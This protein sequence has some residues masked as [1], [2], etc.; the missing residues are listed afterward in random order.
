M[1]TDK[2]ACIGWEMSETEAVSLKLELEKALKQKAA[3]EERLV[4]VDA[5]LKECMQQLR[6]VR[7]EQEKRIHD[8]VM[9]ASND[10][11]RT[12]M[13]L[14]SK[15]DE[16]SKRLAKVDSEN[17]QLRKALLM[18]EKVIEELNKHRAKAEIDSNALMTRLESTEKEN[19]SLKYELRVLE[20]ELEIR[21]EEREFN[22]RTAD[23][24]NKQ[25]LENVKKIAKLESECQR[26][27]LLVRKRLP[28]PATLAKMKNEVDMLS[29]DQ[30]ET[31]RRKSNP[32]MV[33]SMDFS[34]DMASETPRKSKNY[35]N[36]QLYVMEEENRT[37][38]EAITK[39]TNELHFSRNMFA[40]EEPGRT[41]DSMH[42]LSR[43]SIS[44][45][46][47]D[48]KVS[49]AESWASALISE[50][51]QF[52]IGKQEGVPS[53]TVGASDMSLM[54]DFV[55]M[56]KLAVLAV[57]SPI[58][59]SNHGVE[60]SV[61]HSPLTVQ[62]SEN[63]HEATA[64]ASIPDDPSDKSVSN[65]QYQPKD[66]ARKLAPS[67]LDEILAIILE[68]SQ[69]LQRKPNDVLEEIK[70]AL[71]LSEKSS[72]H[73]DICSS[74]NSMAQR[75]PDESLNVEL[76]D[77]G[78][79]N[80]VLT[81]KKSN[82]K[83]QSNLSTSICKIVKL[84]E[85]I[86]IQSLHDGKSE[87]STGY[88]VRLFQWKA[89]E[90]S[91]TLEKFIQVCNDLL[92]G[93]SDL[94]NFAEQLNCTLDWIMNH[95]FSL[96]DV[97]SMKNAIK[98]HLDWDESRS[99]SEVDSGTTNH[100]SESSKMH[101]ELEEVEEVQHGEREENGRLKDES[102]SNKSTKKDLEE[103]LQV[104]ILKSESQ[105][106]QL[107]ESC[108]T[109]ES[110]QNE[111]ENLKQLKEKIE[112]E[113]EKDK[114]VKEDLETQLTKAKNEL[115]KAFG[116]LVYLEKELENKNNSSASNTICHDLQHELKRYILS[117]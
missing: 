72:S 54:D 10:F 65:H 1:F 117:L 15:L 6:F 21:N 58:E 29:K 26:L 43:A 35:L 67:W 98:D 76:S 23:V 101:L 40:Q 61:A 30:P 42:E 77:E 87:T 20:K 96:Q 27:R 50:L 69:V 32:T 115:S 45:M 92:N 14:H 24:S 81:G 17:A 114:M 19:T 3:S 57:D 64:A 113:T 9:K 18:K 37:P 31:R 49:C 95:C 25:H 103:R 56:E 86:S 60:N 85:G 97:S 47:S 28:G 12:R 90:L 8:A 79:G 39:R 34:V 112:V 94:E 68:K 111:V 88:V 89:S 46:G 11:Q 91:A 78:A 107:Q 70:G 48:D 55:E 75:S 13:E 99:E 100:L 5:A 52:K 33:G 106:I 74:I 104:E 4:H 71:P 109:I 102:P 80:N 53:R 7:E 51:E 110:L 63:G 73:L 16:A 82:Q 105:M 2:K 44:D 116:E 22:R 66:A 83:V 62:A 84:I 36:E 59:N 108:K 93:K 41:L 38:K